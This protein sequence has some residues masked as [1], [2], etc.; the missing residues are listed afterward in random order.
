[1][2]HDSVMAV[3]DS[4]PVAVVRYTRLDKGWE[5]GSEELKNHHRACGS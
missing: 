3:K 5:E 1:M 4:I 2:V